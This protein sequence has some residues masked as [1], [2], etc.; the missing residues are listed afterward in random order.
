MKHLNALILLIIILL[1]C[2]GNNLF[3]QTTDDLIFIH[4]S[5]G[6]NW[7]SNSLNT[8]LLAKDYIDERNDITY[9]SVLSPDTDRLAS[10]A[11]TP[12][13]KTDMNHWILWFNDYLE[14]VKT[15]DCSDGENKII[16][17]KSCYP[18]SN[19]YSDG[20]EPGDPF[21]AIRN[22]VNYKAVYRH[23]DGAGNTYTHNEKTYYPLEDIFA[24]NP[25]TLFIAVTAPPR[26]YGPTDA[27]DDAQ[28]QRARDFNNWL[29]T[30][31]LD[32]YNTANPGLNNVAVFDWFNILAYPEDHA[33]HPNRLREEYGGNDG[34]SHPNSTANAYSTMQF[35]S[36][37]TNFIDT[38]WDLF[39][40][41]VPVELSSFYAETGAQGVTL[42]WS[43]ASEQL[44]V[45]WNIYRADTDNTQQ[46]INNFIIPGYGTSA[47]EH[48][49]E[50]IDPSQ[51]IN[52]QTYTYLL[53]SIDAAGNTEK[54]PG[55][56]V[57]AT[58]G[59]TLPGTYALKANYPNPFNSR[60]VIPYTVPERSH[61]TLNIYDVRGKLV[62]TLVNN[63]QSAG[64]YHAVWDADGLSSG[65][66]FCRLKT[67]EF[68]RTIKLLYI[69]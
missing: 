63:E 2:T 25:N 64:E 51:L 14:S 67:P 15:W 35:A 36:N 12:G 28:A 59:S 18:I 5:C 33:D 17:F 50:Y 39:N 41:T 44:N 56:S 6:A 45:G 46:K 47:F 7:L 37:E 40:S 34:D 29:K 53:E 20:T 65:T 27:T 58:G 62:Q 48:N 66:Y 31:W 43:T 54:H 1:L 52:G 23:P 10:L 30:D 57:T 11:P 24:A 68:N 38:A 55:I 19:I 21:S 9:G 22:V 8:A 26:N 61:V 69:K 49:Y 3:A 4:H 60:T 42:Y 16:L 13:D 32:S